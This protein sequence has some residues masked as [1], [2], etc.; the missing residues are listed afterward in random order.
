MSNETKVENYTK[1]ELC[2]IYLYLLLTFAQAIPLILVAQ[3]RVFVEV[4]SKS[5]SGPLGGCTYRLLALGVPVGRAGGQAG[6]AEA[7]RNEGYLGNRPPMPQ[8]LTVGGIYPG[9]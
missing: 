3:F 7:V 4:S 9:G 2:I 6:A 5:R 8:R 1:P